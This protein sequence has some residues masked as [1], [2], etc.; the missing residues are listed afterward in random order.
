MLLSKISS[1][2]ENSKITG[3]EYVQKYFSEAECKVHARSPEEYRRT[4]GD[5]RAISLE[6]AYIMEMYL[7]G[8]Y[9]TAIMFDEAP[10]PPKPQKPVKANG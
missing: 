1:Q 7:A 5:R 10:P 6:A 4:H 3:F 2:K 9:D 8:G